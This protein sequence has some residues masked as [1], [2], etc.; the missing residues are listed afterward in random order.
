[1]EILFFFFFF[2]VEYLLR[3]LLEILREIHKILG[4]NSEEIGRYGGF[5]V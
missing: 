4:R 2:V 5:V 1:M 3:Y